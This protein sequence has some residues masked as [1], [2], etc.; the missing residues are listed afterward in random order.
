VKLRA[1]VDLHTVRAHHF[2][3]SFDGTTNTLF[4]DPAAQ[5]NFLRLWREIGARIGK[6]PVDA[7]AYEIMNEPMAKDHADWNRL[8]ARA[9][10]DIRS[11]EPQRVLVIG[12]N[13]WQTAGTFPY[14]EVPK[15]DRN[16][17]LSVHTYAPLAFTHYK[18]Y[19]TELKGYK[20]QVH[21]PGK[22]IDDADW[23]RYEDRK[24]PAVMARLDDARIPF[25]PEAL[26]AVLAPAIEKARALGLQ[27][28]CGEFGCL[29]SV[30]R[31]DR[32]A[33]YNDIID[34]FQSNDLAWANWDYKGDFG[35]VGFDRDKGVNLDRDEGLIEALLATGTPAP[36]FPAKP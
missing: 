29:P 5:A 36:P 22:A 1:I 10:A 24:T 3:A 15:G 28:Y 4:T 21:Y 26:R 23:E 14:L 9:V 2:N 20:G 17:I 30:E 6:F 27:L 12:S 31:K 11:R 13:I 34:V 16:I 33:Y 18:A 35:I 32:L 25:G 19:W 8:V 7:V